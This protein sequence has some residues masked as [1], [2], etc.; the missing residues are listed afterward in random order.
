MSAPP[1]PHRR[2]AG[3]KRPTLGAPAE[4]ERRVEAAVVPGRP[5]RRVSQGARTGGASERVLT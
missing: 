2:R 3:D 1:P 4:K 5:R